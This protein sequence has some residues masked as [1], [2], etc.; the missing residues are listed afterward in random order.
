MP[1]E[2]IGTWTVAELLQGAQ[3][4][5]DFLWSRLPFDVHADQ[6]K[7]EPQIIL[8]TLRL[9]IDELAESERLQRE[10]LEEIKRVATADGLTIIRGWAPVMGSPSE[11]VLEMVDAALAGIAVELRTKVSSR[12]GCDCVNNVPAICEAV[13]Y[14]CDTCDKW[15]RKGD[16]DES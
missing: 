1:S 13:G 10:A 6:S 14:P 8:D 5:V 11:R 12:R 7:Y 4:L 16:Q 2:D 9:R 15:E 3:N